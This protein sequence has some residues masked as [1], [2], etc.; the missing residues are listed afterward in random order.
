MREVAGE[1][2]E[3][4]TDLHGRVYGIIYFDGGWLDRVHED[5]RELHSAGR[6]SDGRAMS[7][8]KFVGE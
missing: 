6:D 8:L 2:G 1:E 5:E 7:E 3:T 4:G